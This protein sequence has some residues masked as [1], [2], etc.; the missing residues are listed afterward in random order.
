MN[1]NTLTAYRKTRSELSE[2]NRLILH[3]CELRT[4]Q[5]GMTDRYIKDGLF[6]PDMNCVRPRITELIR[7]GWLIE[8]GST[9]CS[10]TGMTVRVVRAATEEERNAQVQQ[11]LFA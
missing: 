10:V 2:R 6:L 7:D 3:F 9:R 1:P 11:E 5:G 4:W 8:C